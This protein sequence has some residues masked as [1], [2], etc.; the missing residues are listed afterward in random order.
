MYFDR[1]PVDIDLLSSVI[2]LKVGRVCVCVCVYVC[3]CMCVC[4][5]AC[6]HAFYISLLSMSNDQWRA[7]AQTCR[8][9]LSKTACGTL[10]IKTLTAIFIDVR[11]FASQL[12]QSHTN[13]VIYHAKRT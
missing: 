2:R 12:L 3:V 11:E 10:V 7:M 6:M 4:V 9:L 8:G 13:V 5:R 1:S